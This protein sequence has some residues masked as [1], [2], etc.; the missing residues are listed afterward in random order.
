MEP[1]A[2]P[3]TAVA[4]V[5]YHLER[6]GPGL[7][8]PLSAFPRFPDCTPGGVQCLHVCM[9]GLHT[10][11]LLWGWNK[12]SNPSRRVASISFLRFSPGNIFSNS[13]TVFPCMSFISH[14]CP[15]QGQCPRASHRDTGQS[16]ERCANLSSLWVASVYDLFSELKKVGYTLL[17]QPRPFSTWIPSRQEETCLGKWITAPHN[18]Y[19]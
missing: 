17:R 1:W 6:N 12:I 15:R 14:N 4:A 13:G 3:C 2:L 10:C 18:S 7:S 11:G 19:P 16:P 5:S 8:G 9:R